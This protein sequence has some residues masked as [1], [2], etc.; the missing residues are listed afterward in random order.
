[1]SKPPTIADLT[2]QHDLVFEATSA[3]QRMT[4]D[5]DSRLALSPIQTL[6]ISLTGCMAV[7][8]AHILTKGRHPFRAIRAHIVGDRAQDTPHRFLKVTLT[9]TVEG[10]LSSESVGRAIALSHD[11]YCS[12]WHSMRQD[13]AFTTAFEVQ[14]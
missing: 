6:A 7:D 2:W 8:V 13:I 11:K 3:T 12:V 10:D 4:L 1:V 14:P 5:G 9:F